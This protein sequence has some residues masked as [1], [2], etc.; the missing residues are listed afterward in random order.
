MLNFN[1][2][3]MKTKIKFALLIFTLLSTSL[4]ISCDKDDEAVVVDDTTSGLSTVDAD[5]L[6]F[7][8]EEEKLARDAYLYMHETWGTEIFYNISTS[9]Q[10]HMDLLLKRIEQFELTDIASTDTGVFNNADLQD[11]YDQ[12][13]DS[14][15]DSLIAGLIVGATIEE[16]DIVDLH[17]YIDAT[18]NEDLKCTYDV[19]LLGSRNH[20]RG[21]IKNLNNNNYSYTP[22][23]LTQEKYDEIINGSHEQGHSCD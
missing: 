14:G 12:L 4:I 19:L 2:F 20:L 1:L 13:I 23:F 8:R 21:F 18:S 3:A 6:L 17:K 5:G 10:S 16:V 9:E 22:Q 15:K 11:L 7:M